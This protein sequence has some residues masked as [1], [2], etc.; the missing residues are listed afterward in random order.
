[1]TRKAFR[2]V[3]T[4]FLRSY[5]SRYS[6]SGGWWIFGLIADDLHKLD[7]DLLV[8]PGKSR[9]SFLN[10]ASQLARKK[11][12]EQVQKHGLV[13]SYLR[14]ARLTAEQLPGSNVGSVNGRKVNG[15]D[16]R[17]K[18]AAVSDLGKRFNAEEIVFV[19]PHNARVELQSMRATGLTARIRRL[20][21]RVRWVTSR[22]CRPRRERSSNS[23]GGT[24]ER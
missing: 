13:L 19:A 17:F 15:H 8:P 11:F 24:A 21:Y 3:L 23:R 6:D 16:V 9:R 20:K 1:M 18:V 5:T 10:E 14:E 2:S 22:W 7:V 12:Q 4:N